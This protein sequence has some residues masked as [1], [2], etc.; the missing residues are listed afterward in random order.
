MPGSSLN[1]GLRL[2][3]GTRGETLAAALT[4]TGCGAGE[5]DRHLW[6]D[7]SGAPGHRAFA[8]ARALSGG[9][10]SCVVLSLH[11]ASVAT[12]DER[13]VGGVDADMI[14][15]CQGFVSG[16]GLLI[17]RMDE[18]TESGASDLVVHPYSGD[19]VKPRFEA[20]LA[21]L[22]ESAPPDAGD[23][24]ATWA[25]KASADQDRV[26]SELLRSWSDPP[27]SAGHASRHAL[28]APRGRGKS[29]ALAR[30]LGA[31][32]PGTR[33]AIC[34]S[35]PSATAT[36]VAHTPALAE[37][38]MTPE[39]LCAEAGYDVVAVDEA[40]QI[41]VATLKRMVARQRDAHLVFATT[42]DGYEGTGGGFVLRFLE[43][44]KAEGGSV[45]SMDTPIRWA[46]NDPL[47]ELMNRA[48]LMR[49][50]AAPITGDP[51]GFRL[52]ELG[53]DAL[54]ADESLLAQVYGLL[55]HAHY[56][57]TPS[58][59]R[60]IMNAPNLRLHVAEADS[61]VLAANLI[62][63]EGAL[64]GAL[65][66]ELYLGKRRVRGHALADLLVTH[67]GHVQSG[68]L[69]AIRSVRIAT[70]PDARRRQ[71]ARK[72][73]EHMHSGY[74]PDYFGTMFGATP[75]LIRFRRTCGYEVVRLGV[76]AGVRSGEPTVAMMRAA[77][78]A[79]RALLAAL[80]SELARDLPEQ[81]R[82]MCADDVVT[83]APEL[84][85]SITADLPLPSPFTEAVEDEAISAWALGPRPFELRAEA[86][87][88]RLDRY[89]R[90]LAKLPEDCR[91]MLTTRLFERRSWA[92]AAQAAEQPSVRAAMRRLRRAVKH[93]LTVE[94]VAEQ[95]RREG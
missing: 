92:I 85:E 63:L 38:L 31:L 44:L 89:P 18:A 28:I 11:S 6:V 20:R 88:R 17:L 52:K 9:T 59:L 93:Q 14:A 34:G 81:L 27:R 53:Q 40:A 55:K 86:I 16:G 66:R 68:G 21:A 24:A 94:G 12:S 3:R 87:R 35:T 15:L 78:D 30:A 72:L 23:P 49:S 4:L 26:V 39:R 90:F 84:I 67:G 41:P 83:L 64:P 32:S 57:T 1:R 46:P 75:E 54:A 8:E 62:A 56:R 50:A 13:G 74:A 65:C 42:T 51:G 77:S 10:Y 71:I 80:R 36:L 76:S 73:T 43:W 47:E 61:G 60:R 19:D 58:D 7:A 45:L 29:V 22:L 91:V 5:T 25:T 69:R 33:I 79:G 70:H 95:I 37:R 82:L 48:L 2:L